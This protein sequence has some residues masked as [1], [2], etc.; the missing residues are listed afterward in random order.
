MAANMRMRTTAFMSVRALPRA[1]QFPNNNF[2]GIAIVHRQLMPARALGGPVTGL[3]Q[4]RFFST[5]EII[6]M[7]VPDL[8][9]E[10]IT[11]S[12]DTFAC[13]HT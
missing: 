4:V 3:P 10:S 12:T 13:F 5:G 2:R 1:V 6:E 11:E 8:G 9:A 7:V